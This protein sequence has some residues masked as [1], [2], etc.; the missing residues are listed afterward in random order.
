MA[1]CNW[2]NCCHDN[3]SYFIS[4]AIR[5][6]SDIAQQFMGALTMSNLL[7]IGINHLPE[8]D[9][10]FVSLDIHYIGEMTSVC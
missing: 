4:I 8:F 9:Y 3:T 6:D 7:V 1:G 10:G 5:M 2:I